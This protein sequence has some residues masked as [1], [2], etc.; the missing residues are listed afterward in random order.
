MSEKEKLKKEN[1]SST[2]KKT[3]EDNKSYIKIGNIEISVGMLFTYIYLLSSIIITINNR[4][5]YQKYNFKFNFSLM[6]MQQFVCSVL[7]FLG[8]KYSKNFQK[9][10]GEIS[11]EDFL[12]LKG[13]YA[14]F[15]LLF[16]L[17]ILSSFYG[18]QLVI[19]TAMFL[20]LRKF[21]AVMTYLY[22]IFIDHKELES[23]FTVSILL[24]TSGSIISGLD[25]FTYDLVG[26]IVVFINNALSVIYAKV[27]EKFRK[28]N[29]I[30][31]VK[32]LI[33]NSFLITPF[34]LVLIIISG[35]GNRLL[36]YLEKNKDNNLLGLYLGLLSSCILCL[37]LN[38][39]YFF[40]NEK[41]SSL[42]TQLFGNCRDILVTG[43]SMITLRDF[44]PTFKTIFG[45]ILSTFGALFFSMKS[46]FK[47]MKF[48]S[49]TDEKKKQ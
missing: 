35:E 17:N 39:S 3:E 43:L 36:L 41:N 26:Y 18:N 27:S 48:S 19:N 21:L 24:I 34:L 2:P 9:Q 33:Y 25:D 10:A 12:K 16:G 30:S 13:Q 44:V 8:S 29:G 4:F 5:L 7:F 28:K 6:F 31:N 46:M 40:S 37:I 1:S 22:D 20:I 32:L 45:L 38:S 14:F 42:F 49:K 23:Y 11:F 47:N 15:S